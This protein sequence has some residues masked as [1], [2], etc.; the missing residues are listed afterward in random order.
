MIIKVVL[1]AAVLAFGALLLRERFPG[2][3][4]ALRRLVG[5]GVVLAGVASVIWPLAVTWAANRVG[6]GRGTDL[7]LYVLVIVFLFTTLAMY[8]RM[9]H[10]ESKLTSLARA[11]ALERA[12]KE[13][14]SP[15]PGGE[16][17]A[18]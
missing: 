4:Q 7:V 13:T 5:L 16:D 18:A 17:V 15:D 14:H 2:Q 8:Q 6:V 9:H 1:V 11:I 12:V 10:L 3:R